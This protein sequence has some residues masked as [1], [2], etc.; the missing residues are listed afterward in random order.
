[1]AKDFLADIPAGNNGH[2]FINC[3]LVAA[4]ASG[5]ADA[6]VTGAGFVAHADMKLL[7]AWKF[8]LRADEV[9]KG[10]AT[11]SASY[12]RHT[13]V[14]GGTAGTGTTLLASLNA[15]ASQAS[16]GKRAYTMVADVTIAK[17]EIVYLSHL[18]VGAATADGTDS[19]A[20]MVG[21]AYQLL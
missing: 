14:N 3:G 7:A 12:R 8:D 16:L 5:G 9:T 21:V 20:C 2:G 11:T 18:S 4:V 1:M 13:I 17:G 10:T 19:A 15:T 6:R